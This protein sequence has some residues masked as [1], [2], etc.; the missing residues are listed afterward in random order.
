MKLFDEICS[1]NNL[2][3]AFD[4]VEDNAGVPGIDGVT[5]EEFSIWLEKKLLLLREQLKN[6]TY[7]PDALLK[8]SIT[9]D[10]GKIRNLSIPTVRDRI[11]QTS[12]AI[13]LDR[14]L[15]EEFENCSFAYRRG[16]SVQKAVQK[17]VDLRDKGYVW[18]VDADISSFF[19]EVDHDILIREVRKYIED[20]RVVD[21]IKKWL[22]VDVIYKGK[23]TRL[24]KGVPM[25]SPVSPL[26]SNL[27]LD[28]F[29]EALLKEKQK[30]VRFSD[31]FVIL[32]KNQPDAED[33]L[34]LTEDVLRNLRLNLNYMTFGQI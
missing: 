29:D 2:L 34:E 27:Y 1:Y 17:I 23:R 6:G 32:C 11:V 5:I 26:L 30:I 31:D 18:V 20:E 10:S 25:G 14:E 16:R 33:A 19:D 3:L 8:I 22:K 13:I 9:E 28:Y 4:R 21:L 15:D 24:L 7:K 12:A